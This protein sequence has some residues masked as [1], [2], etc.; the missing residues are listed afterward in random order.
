MLGAEMWLRKPFTCGVPHAN[1]I[2]VRMTH[3][4]IATRSGSRRPPRFG[5]GSAAN[6]GDAPLRPSPHARKSASD[7]HRARG[8]DDVDQPRT[9]KVRHEKLRNR[10]RHA[11]DEHRRPDLLHAAPS[12]V[13]RD[14]PERHDQREDRQLSSDHRAQRAEIE[15]RHA[16]QRDDRRA[17]RA[18]RDRRRVGDQR[19]RRRL[20]RRKAEADENRAGHR[21]RRSE[22]GRALEERAEAKRDEQ[23]LKSSISRDARDRALQR[24]EDAAL[25]GERDRET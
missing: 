7:N 21:D 20:E 19:Q 15:S 25:L 3:G 18:E 4:M 2:T 9:V 11:G 16:L 14:Q 5:S 24:D 17:E 1:T 23:K 6:R 8:G 22:S 13:R 10:E 12:G